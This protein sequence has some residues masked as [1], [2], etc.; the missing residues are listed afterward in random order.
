MTH[1]QIFDAIEQG[2]PEWFAQR[3]GIPT[4][5]N[6]A[7]VLAKGEGKVRSEY[8]RKLAGEI[9]TGEQAESYSNGHMERG[10]EMEEE[11]RQAFVFLTDAEPRQ[12]GFIRNDK[13]GV[14][15]S[16]DSLIGETGG[17]EI[18]TALPHIQID[19]LEKNK[20][21]PEHMAQVQGSLWVAE[22]DIW[23][24]VSYWP[25]MPPLIVVVHRDD[26]YIK[27]LASEMLRFREELQAMVWRIKNYGNPAAG[28]AALKSA[29]V[30]S[31]AA[32]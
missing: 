17:L 5:S 12:I 10:K 24:F 30:Q 26:E 3:L 23:H 20:L 27:T 22:R 19:R 21:P 7:K 13:Y 1:I 15:C 25:K 8:M 32:G 11:A 6:F 16:P 28:S 31:I 2:S 29:L 14:G 9:I 4:A 18:K